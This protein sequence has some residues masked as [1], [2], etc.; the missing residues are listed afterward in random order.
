M[1]RS[2]LHSL[3]RRLFEHERYASLTI[4]RTKLQMKSDDLRALS[5][6]NSMRVLIKLDVA[7]SLLLSGMCLMVKFAKGFFCERSMST[8]K[9]RHT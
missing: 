6:C 2:P 9:L 5:R 4:S 7:M 1:V 3:Q 8:D